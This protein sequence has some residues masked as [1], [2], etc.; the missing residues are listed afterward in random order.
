MKVAALFVDENG[1][2]YQDERFDAW[3]I[4]RDARTFVGLAPAVA[5]PPCARYGGYAWGSP[6][7]QVKRM[8]DDGGAFHVSLSVIRAN[9]G[10]LEHPQGSLAWEWFGLPIPPSKGWSH[11]DSWGGRSCQIDQ[12]VYGHPCKKRTWLYAVLPA[13]PELDWGACTEYRLIESLSS[14][15]AWRWKTP[16]LLKDELYNMAASCV[17][18][19][20]KR[21]HKQSILAVG[22][23]A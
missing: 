18:W 8:G 4:S 12:G 19:V 20:P 6:S 5:H 15:D 7:N 23:G 11:V 10:V 16:D 1:P 14:G 22:G 17:G 21:G 13:F 3:G 2:Y 9:G